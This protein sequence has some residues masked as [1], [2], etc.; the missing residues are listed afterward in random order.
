MSEDK[1][2]YTSYI[3]VVM[4]AK[5]A[6]WGRPAILHRP[7]RYRIVR[8]L[9]CA[10]GSVTRECW[11]KGRKALDSVFDVEDNIISPC[12]RLGGML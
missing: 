10:Y 12:Y 3:L 9:V 2:S 4:S 1:T 8:T 7:H 5:L 11:S 6:L